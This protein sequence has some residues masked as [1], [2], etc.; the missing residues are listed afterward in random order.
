MDARSEAGKSL[1]EPP[2]VPIAV[3]A[4]PTMTTSLRWAM[5][6]PDSGFKLSW[7]YYFMFWPVRD[8]SA[9]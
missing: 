3:R 7:V 5:I 6:F 2:K 4:A 1:S 9:D 8:V